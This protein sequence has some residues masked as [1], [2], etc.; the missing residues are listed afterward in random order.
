ML[1]SEKKKSLKFEWSDL[2]EN[3][4]R[5]IYSFYVYPGYST[6]LY[7]LLLY[8][9]VLEFYSASMIKYRVWTL[10]P[11]RESDT[12]HKTHQNKMMMIDI[13]QYCTLL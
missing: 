2:A 9:G 13:G 11:R 6:V 7:S 12:K 10:A 8:T 1:C 5:F 3:N 4:N